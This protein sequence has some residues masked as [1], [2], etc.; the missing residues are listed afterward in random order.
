M[1]IVFEGGDGVGK[2][3]QITQVSRHLNRMGIAHITTREPGGTP[4]AEAIRQAL[5]YEKNQPW[6]LWAEVFLVA[7]A[8]AHHLA[9][10]IRPALARGD[11]VLCDRF[12]ESTRAYQHQAYTENP[13]LFDAILHQATGGLRP[14]LTFVFHLNEG[15]RLSRR[16]RNHADC[17][18]SRNHDFQHQVAAHFAKLAQNPPADYVFLQADQP[19][20]TLTEMIVDTLM[21]KHADGV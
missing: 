19:I 12:C 14:D 16:P 8:R 21:A 3:T 6:P 18:E 11:W 20:G 9:H 4:P 5:L 1:F 17:F 7:A 13:A 15:E 10:V 2:S